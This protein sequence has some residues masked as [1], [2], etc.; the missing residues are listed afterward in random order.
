[1]LWIHRL[2]KLSERHAS[3]GQSAC[4]NLFS[5]GQAGIYNQADTSENQ[6]GSSEGCRLQK[7]TAR[8][9]L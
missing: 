6:A 8:D 9:G 1:M 7:I 5:E 2:F 4:V 3:K